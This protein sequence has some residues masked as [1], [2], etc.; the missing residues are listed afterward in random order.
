MNGFIKEEDINEVRERNDLVEVISEYVP[1]KKSG[2]TFKALCP[3]HKEKT[4]S[5]IV[6]P[7]KQ[8]YHCFGCGIGGGVFTFVMK[9]DNIDFP[10]AVRALADRVGY[11]LQYERGSKESQSRR[12]RLY[13]A[14]KETMNFFHNLLKSEEGRK[15]REYLKNRG[16][17]AE[18]IDAFKLGLAPS[19]W[20]GLLNSLCG[21]GFKL[22]E[23]E[24]A[25]LI[26]KGEKGFYDRFRS[27]IMFPIFDVRG[28]VIAFGGRILDDSQNLSESPKYMNSPETPIYNK[29]SILYGLYHSKSEIAKTGQSLV[30]EGYTDVLSLRAMGIRNVVATC[31]TAFTSDHLRLLARFGERVILVF[32]ADVAGTAAVERGL[33]LLGESKVDIYVVSLPMG[34][35][36]ADFIAEHGR[37]E[38]KKLLKDAVPLIDFCLKQVLSQ[39][40][41][42]ESLQ[43]AKA[44]SEALTIIAAL[45]NAVAQ[46]GYLKKLADELNVSLDSLFFELK[47]LKRSKTKRASKEVSEDLVI[48]SAQ[49][50]AE[51][52]LLR[53]ILQYPEECKAA[54]AELDEEHFTLPD[55]RELFTILKSRAHYR[56]DEHLQEL[57]LNTFKREELQ[58]LISKLML[59][60]VEVEEREKYFKDILL[61]LKEFE[62][63]RQINTLKPKLER[64]NPIKNPIKYDALFEELLKLEAKRRNL[65]SSL[66]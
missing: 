41:L 50:K 23:L 58:K 17:D 1:L 46:E 43:R 21:R 65:R 44:S 33:E 66:S 61:R 32:D 8:L 60:P 47:R 2:R 29:S 22:D 27:R 26:I 45:K 20:D 37:S 34:T 54:L 55:C 10:D 35:D 40:N 49:E 57:L 4:P 12:A 62:I 24:E 28:R 25:G 18:I 30:V 6:D 56:S 42:S 11:T 14:N 52:E 38:F 53:L 64:I 39:Y 9:M 31:G 13:E 5:F 51:Q 16:Y 48:T 3:F 63:Q 19:R 36:P 15:A 7:V 59:Q